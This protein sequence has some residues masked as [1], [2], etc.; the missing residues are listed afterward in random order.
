MIVAGTKD[1][2]S[3]AGHSDTESY[4]TSVTENYTRVKGLSNE[5]FTD[6]RGCILFIY[7]TNYNYSP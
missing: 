5:S 2:G 4:A 7:V 1:T 6:T 3:N